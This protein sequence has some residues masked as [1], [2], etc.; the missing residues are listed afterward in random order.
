MTDKQAE[1]DT[2]LLSLYHSTVEA[3]VF[4]YALEAYEDLYDEDEDE[5]IRALFFAQGDRSHCIII[6][7]LGKIK[8][9]FTLKANGVPVRSGYMPSDLL[10]QISNSI[11][12]LTHKIYESD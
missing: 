3:E 5:T 8:E 7:P 10:V 12:S 11:S 2:S 6:N 9:A 4:N 1:L